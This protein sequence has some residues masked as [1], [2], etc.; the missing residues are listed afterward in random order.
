MGYS[1]NTQFSPLT[2]KVNLYTDGCG[3]SYG[4]K[5][6]VNGTYIDLCG[7]PVE[8][9]MKNPFCCGNNSGSSD[10]PVKPVNQIT[11]K[12]FEDENGVIYYQAFAQF[13]VASNIKVYVSSTTEVVTELDLYAGNTASQPE[14]GETFDFLVAT[15]S[16]EEDETYRYVMASEE[17]KITYN[18]YTKAV[19]TSAVQDFTDDFTK[20]V[21]EVGTTS[22]IRFKINGTDFNY[23]DITDI[24]E[25]NEFCLANVHSFVLYI[26][27]DVYDKKA[28]TISNYGGSDITGKFVFKHEKDIDDM[29]YVA[30]AEESTI[31]I[32]PF[33]PLYKE[34]IIY[35]Y[36]LTLNKS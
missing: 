28:Y 23:N 8:E 31:D 2:D 11:V 17:T 1:S 34:D 22:D 20:T 3:N 30:L 7:L 6:Y 27:K 19:L 36:K 9:Y 4:D 13:A 32:M 21:M 24:T 25:F 5:Y 16:I 10:E 33:V 26:P 18:I 12:T 14:I 35:D 15:I 29:K